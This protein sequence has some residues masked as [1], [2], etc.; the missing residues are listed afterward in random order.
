MSVD[1]PLHTITV[2]QGNSAGLTPGTYVRLLDLVHWL[3]MRG[4]GRTGQAISEQALNGE[5]SAVKGANIDGAGNTV[6]TGKEITKRKT[7]GA[8]REA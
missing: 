3:N 4:K 7:R 5:M 8:A 2:A 1:P 6:A